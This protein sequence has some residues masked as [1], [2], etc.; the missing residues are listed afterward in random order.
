MSSKTRC[1]PKVG[2]HYT[3][4]PSR[5]PPPACTMTHLPHGGGYFKA[6][7]RCDEAGSWRIWDLAAVWVCLPLHLS[8]F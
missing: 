4:T 3:H 5:R 2:L 1:C 7:E 8:G 6:A